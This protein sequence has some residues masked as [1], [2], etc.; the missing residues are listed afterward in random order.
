MRQESLYVLRLWREGDLPEAWRASLEDVR[1][2]E[3]VSFNTLTDPYS[4]LE[5]RCG[6]SRNGEPLR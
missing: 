6:V 3:K 4:F 1:S 5:D 2:R